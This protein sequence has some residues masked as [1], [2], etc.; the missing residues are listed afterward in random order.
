VIEIA[1][2]HILR[3][4]RKEYIPGWSQESENLYNEYQKTNDNLEADK[5]LSSLSLKPARKNG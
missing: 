3:G 1:R 4:Y 2:K 5:L